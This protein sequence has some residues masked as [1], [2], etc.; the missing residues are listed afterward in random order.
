MIPADE[1]LKG[2]EEKPV[3]YYIYCYFDK[4]LNRWNQP[5]IDTNEPAFI[6]ESTVASIAKGKFPAEQCL[7]LDLVF[8]G[9]FDLKTGHFDIFEEPRIIVDCERVLK[10]DKVDA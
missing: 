1:F 5:V 2:L 8:L 3:L 10:G 6:H 7:D 9:T 4:K